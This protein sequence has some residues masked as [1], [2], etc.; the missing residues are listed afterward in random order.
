MIDNYYSL[1]VMKRCS[2]INLPHFYFHLKK[3]NYIFTPS[4]QPTHLTPLILSSR[5][6]SEFFIWWRGA[7]ERIMHLAIQKP[8]LSV[9]D[10]RRTQ[11]QPR[12][13]ED[14]TNSDIEAVKFMKSMVNS[15]I[16]SLIILIIDEY[17]CI[18][19]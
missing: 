15:L 11:T 10:I 2:S 3:K 18:V 12:L 5:A 17:I 7:P 4:V 6:H 9:E 16:F 1:L 19:G 8:L 14:N 13:V